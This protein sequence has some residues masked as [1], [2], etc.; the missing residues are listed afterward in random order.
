MLMR[1]ADRILSRT[2]KRTVL[3]NGII[4]PG[5]LE[6]Q[7]IAA[8]HEDGTCFV[9]EGYTHR[10]EFREPLQRLQGL[11]LFPNV[12]RYEARSLEMIRQ[13]YDP[14]T[15]GGVQNAFAESVDARGQ[16]RLLE[17]IEA[18]ASARASDIKI[19][20]HDTETL[21]RFKVAG[22]ELDFGHPWTA[23]EGNAAI[24]FA[25]DAGDKGSGETSRKAEGFQSF[26]ITPRPKFSLPDNV[27]KL[28]GQMGHFESDARLGAFMVLRLFYKDDSDTGKLSDLGFDP[29]LTQKLA[30][31][32]ADLKGCVIIGG[33]TGD[34]K[35]TTLIRALEALYD[36]HDGRVGIATLEDPV[37]YRIRRNGLIQIPLRSAGKEEDRHANYRDALRNFMRVNPDVGMVSEIR[38]GAGGSEVLQFAMSGHAIYSTV[39]VDS[40]NGIPF[41]LISLGVAAA[42]LSQ[43]GILRLLIKQTLVP[44]LC[45]HCK[46]PLSDAHLSA[47][48]RL[49]VEPVG[50]DP[51][52]VFLRN[53][54]GCEHCRKGDTDL[55]REAWAGYQRQI[56]VG[57]VIEPD[58]EYCEQVR[59]GH[60]NGA[61]SHWLRP[62]SEGGL[63]GIT[64]SQKV[65]ELV[66]TGRVD[67]RDALRKHV[68]LKQ[69]LTAHQRAELKWAVGA[70]A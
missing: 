39:H 14:N 33:E 22:R 65:V 48:E 47:E 67:P 13:L 8:M 26:S 52:T 10:D 58:R 28:R 12:V 3:V 57:E 60:F 20:Q 24:S 66:V 19:Y 68:D 54:E 43:T 40:A 21:V 30:Q 2:P 50:D 32:R 44:L 62:C 35:S 16:K 45:N 4:Q 5:D 17:A 9:A 6:F 38:D 59:A 34:G 29:E 27:V 64:L 15:T 49:M 23:P 42:D 63:G 11:G 69:R 18:A 51:T 61:L 56:A 53:E 70:D 25:I 46:I 55:G 37:E 36:A 41:R 1:L 7:S 31:A